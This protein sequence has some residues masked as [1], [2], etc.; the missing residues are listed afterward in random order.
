[1]KVF[2]VAMDCEADAVTRNL[3]DARSET[4]FGRSVVR[5]TLGG[6]ETAV[7]IS[8]IG[9]VNAAAATQLALSSLGADAVLNVGVAG[10]LDPALKVCDVLRVARTV[11]YDF[12][13]S[14]INGTQVGTLNEYSTPFFEMQAVGDWPDAT[15]ATGDRFADGEEVVGFLRGTFGANVCDMELGAIAH[16]CRRAGVPVHSWKLISDVAGSGTQADQY[17]RN[18][19]NCLER[20]A[21]LIPQMFAAV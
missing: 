17:K 13:L 3:A 12:D 8:G 9:K 7:V 20:L 1:M 16:V 5:G 4:L 6:V 2:V 11:Q 18:L 21:A 19:E 14:L 10:G 15:V